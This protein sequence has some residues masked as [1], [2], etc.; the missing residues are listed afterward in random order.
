MTDGSIV[1]TILTHYVTGVEEEVEL[2]TVSSSCWEALLEEEEVEVR[3]ERQARATS[4]RSS[5][6]SP[7]PTSM[8]RVDPL[9]PYRFDLN[10]PRLAQK[11]LNSSIKPYQSFY[12]SAIVSKPG[13]G[14]SRSKRQPRRQEL[15]ELGP[16]SH[17]GPLLPGEE[18][19][20][21]HRA[22]RGRQHQG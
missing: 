10:I 5:S 16:R 8:S 7:S 18:A 6:A 12:Y 22:G 2:Q 15:P 21:D 11:G 4:S 17:Q 9:Q 13:V 3:G 1:E 14:R 19:Q 20:G